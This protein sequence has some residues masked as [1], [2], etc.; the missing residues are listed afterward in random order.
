M[1]SF[2]CNSETKFHWQFK[3]ARTMYNGNKY[4]YYTIFD[5]LRYWCHSRVIQI[6]RKAE[7]NI[8]ISTLIDEWEKQ[9]TTI[10]REYAKPREQNLCATFEVCFEFLYQN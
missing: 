4:H 3:Q 8:N 6:L 5:R 2:Y 7:K 10:L 1:I 9:K